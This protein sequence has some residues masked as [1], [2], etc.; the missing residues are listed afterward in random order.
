MN[1]GNILQLIKSSLYCSI[2]DSFFDYLLPE[3][4]LGTV[5]HDVSLTWRVMKILSMFVRVRLWLR[6]LFSWQARMSLIIK[7]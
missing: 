7:T 2:K 4:N 3:D 1:P 5:T 6:I